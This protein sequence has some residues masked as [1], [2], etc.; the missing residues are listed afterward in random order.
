METG[1][2]SALGSSTQGMVGIASGIIGSGKRKREQRAAQKEYNMNKARYSNL[3]TSNLYANQ[4]NMFEDATVNQQEAK[5]T[6]MQ[7]QQGLAGISE[8]LGQ[9]AGGSGIAAMAQAL[10][11]QSSTDAQSASASIG[12]QEAS[13]QLNT[14]QAA[15]NIQS[16]K[17]AGAETSRELEKDKTSTLLGMSQNRLGAAN[18]AR[19][20]ATKAI[21]QGVGTMAG[22]AESM[23]SDAE[24]I[25]MKGA[26]G[27][28]V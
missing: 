16:Q 11:N 8:T 10:A 13:N 24:K 1:L 21:M 27:G 7:Q 14:Q 25:Y 28:M 5:F 22:S 17:L 20:D 12:Q 18:A 2:A 4:Q 9:A 6:K 23:L 15:T 26:T 19:T 3:D